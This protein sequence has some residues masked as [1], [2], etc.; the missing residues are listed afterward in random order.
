MEG[1][2]EGRMV[3]YVMPDGVHRPAVIV[4]VWNRETGYSNL[5]V[6][7]DGTNDPGGANGIMWKTSVNYSKDPVPGTWHWIER[8]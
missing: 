5:Q 4:R 1:L 8:V 2:T 6:F 3:H 7:T